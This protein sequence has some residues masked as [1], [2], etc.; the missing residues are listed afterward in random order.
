MKAL[1][2]NYCAH[3]VRDERE[4]VSDKWHSI[5]TEEC[6]NVGF[7]HEDGTLLCICVHEVCP[8]TPIVIIPEEVVSEDCDSIDVKIPPDCPLAD[9]PDEEV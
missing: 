5:P 3:L 7:L 6:P 8:G 4:E 2:I 9:V 1:M